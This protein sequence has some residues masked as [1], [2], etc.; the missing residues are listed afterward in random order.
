M[1]A[2]VSVPSAALMRLAVSTMRGMAARLCFYG[3]QRCERLWK[4]PPFPSAP[5]EGQG[6]RPVTEVNIHRPWLYR[7]ANIPAPT[8]QMSSMPKATNT[9]GLWIG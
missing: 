8:L 1:I 7:S 3:Y 5:A 4:K 9:G 6:L 2:Y